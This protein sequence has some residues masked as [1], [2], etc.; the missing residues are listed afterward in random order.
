MLNFQNS[1]VIILQCLLFRVSG[2]VFSVCYIII[3]FFMTILYI[4]F[5]NSCDRSCELKLS[6]IIADIIA[7]V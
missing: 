7:T 2:Y 4:A 3:Y 5:S 6:N 1:S